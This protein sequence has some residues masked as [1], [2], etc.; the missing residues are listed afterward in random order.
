MDSLIKLYANY[1]STIEKRSMG[2][3][4]SEWDEKLVKYGDLFED[5]LMTLSLNLPL[6]KALDT[7]WEILSECFE[8]HEVGLKS[9]LVDKFW[10]TKTNV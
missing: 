4:M 1:K 2:F 9:E 5:R 3:K 6:E 7:G 10:V 8:P